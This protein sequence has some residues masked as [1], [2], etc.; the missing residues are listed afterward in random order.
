MIQD[1]YIVR[2]ANQE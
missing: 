2:M 1:G